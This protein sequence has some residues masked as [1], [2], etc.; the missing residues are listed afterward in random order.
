VLDNRLA[1][2]EFLAGDFSIADIANWTWAR[3][4]GMAGISIEPF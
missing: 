2:H 4:H 3:I 1:D